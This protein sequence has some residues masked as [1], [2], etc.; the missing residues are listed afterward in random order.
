MRLNTKL[1]SAAALA[2]FLA[3]GSVH[4]QNENQQAAEPVNDAQLERFSEAMGEIQEIRQDYSGQLEGVQD[5][6]KAR[7]LQQQA[8]EEMVQAVEDTGM[9]VEEYNN[10]S[11][12]LRQNP[13]LAERLQQMME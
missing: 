6:E 1:L 5:Q 11:Q 12:Q 3:G 9:S 13:E 4:A 10:I 7:E 2:A 8:N